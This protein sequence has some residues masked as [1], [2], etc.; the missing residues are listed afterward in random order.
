MQI[1]DHLHRF[2]FENTPVRGSIV[3]LDDSFQQSLQHHDFP[4]ILRQALGELMA[5]SAL[6][7][8]TL[9]LKGGALVLQVQGKGPLK[10]LVVECTSDLGI[11]ATAKWSGELDG[12]SFSDMVSNGHFVITL[13]PRDGGQPYQGIVPVEGG[14]IAEILQSYMQRSEQIDTRMWLACDGKRA[15]GMLVQKMPDQ[16]DAADPDAWNRIIMLA[17]TVRDEELLDLSAVSLIKRL[18]NEEDVR[19]F[20]EQPIKFHCGC[21]RESVGNMLRMLGEEEVADILAEQHTIDINCDFCNAEYHFDEVDAEQ[22]FTTEIV[23]PG[24]DVR[25]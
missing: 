6:L 4:Q 8:A 18:F 14:S 12:M 16:P 1:S 10:L 25:H 3:H 17:D 23:M 9:K 15:A 13:D 2:L 22:L 19:L 24:N 11:R 5:A 20:K 21:S 7:A